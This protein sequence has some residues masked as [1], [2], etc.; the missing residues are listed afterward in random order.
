LK[1]WVLGIV[2]LVLAVPSMAA[3]RRRALYNMSGRIPLGVESLRAQPARVPFYLMAS[4]DNPAFIGMYRAK[5]KNGRKALFNADNTKVKFYPRHVT[6]RIMATARGK[7]YDDP[8]F[9]VHEGVKL[10]RLFTHIH[11]RLKVF[12]GLFYQYIQP[13]SVKEVGMP[14]SIDYNERVYRIVF[15]LNKLPISDRV[16]IEVIQP[17]GSRLCKFHLDLY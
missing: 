14:E 15:D 5:D 10:D 6:F 1:I 12:H 3:P 4:A 9:D 17:D 8:P 11:F 2:S 13:T 16:V 7:L